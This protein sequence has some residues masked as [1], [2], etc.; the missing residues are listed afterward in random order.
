MR[1]DDLDLDSVFAEYAK[2]E[3]E[4]GIN[5]KA[6]YTLPN[7]FS[8]EDSSD[9]DISSDLEAMASEEREKLY[10]LL[11]D[12]SLLDE[13]HPDGNKRLEGI[14]A[15]DDLAVIEDLRGLK[16]RMLELVHKEMKVKA[17]RIAVE[18]IKL[19]DKL[20]DAGF[21]VFA[22]R[23][24]RTA[25]VLVEAEEPTMQMGEPTMQMGEPKVMDEREA[26]VDNIKDAVNNLF[27]DINPYLA[28]LSNNDRTSYMKASEMLVDA[29]FKLEIAMDEGKVKDSMVALQDGQEV[30]MR[31]WDWTAD[32]HG[33]L[34][35]ANFNLAL[36]YFNRGLKV[37]SE[38][39]KPVREPEDLNKSP[40]VAKVNQKQMMLR[41]Q[42]K[43]NELL[44]K[45]GYDPV[46][47]EVPETGNPADS[48]TYERIRDVF[49]LVAGK[50]YR[51]WQQLL[52]K[53]DQKGRQMLD[54][55]KQKQTQA[56]ESPQS[57]APGFRGPGAQMEP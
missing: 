42:K 43:V 32:I 47:Y 39:P 22:D 12:S 28:R 2:L 45:L 11:P 44:N 4:M 13:A 7:L 24:D 26:L 15:K 31:L 51:N 14:D 1:F 6:T 48:E 34:D 29:I 46:K 8:K 37:L 41:V 55:N 25:A 49:G 52:N 3:E 36:N 21:S 10:G 40:E 17:A 38:Q 27:M 23:L 53:L 54:Q 57:P 9:I 35:K 5:K 20:D 33:F 18:V 50:D 30:L 56:P 16:K 19:A